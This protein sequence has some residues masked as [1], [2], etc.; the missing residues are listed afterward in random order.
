MVFKILMNDC[1]GK[2]GCLFSNLKLQNPRT[3]NDIEKSMFLTITKGVKK[4]YVYSVSTELTVVDG[5]Y[6]T[7]CSRIFAICF[8]NLAENGS[9]NRF[10]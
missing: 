2:V 8:E 10:C 9:C 5:S 6:F 7:R 1:F 3:E 4:L